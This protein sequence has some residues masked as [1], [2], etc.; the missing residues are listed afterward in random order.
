ML[1]FNKFWYVGD[2]VKVKGQEGKFAI[3]EI[4][5]SRKFVKLEG[6]FG[7]FKREQLIKVVY[8]K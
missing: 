6:V 3:S 2:Y 7:Y 1:I 8:N 4:D 5:F